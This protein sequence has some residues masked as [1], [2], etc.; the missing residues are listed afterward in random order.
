MVAYLDSETFVL[1]RPHGPSSSMFGILSKYSR[2][3]LA[4]ISICRIK[5]IKI[6]NSSTE[7]NVRTKK[8]PF[9]ANL[10]VE[11][12]VPS[13]PHTPLNGGRQLLRT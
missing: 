12:S 7:K 2:N 10:F 9:A 1:S 8:T 6:V 4:S 13:S 5:S 11:T 3:I